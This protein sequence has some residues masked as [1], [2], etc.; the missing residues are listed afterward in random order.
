MQRIILDVDTGL[1]DAVALF[2]AAGLEEIK[3]EAV[4]ATAGNVGLDK[5]LENTLNIMETTG[6]DCPVYAGSAAPLV[7]VPVEAGDFHG[8][9]GLDGPI[10][11]TR[12]RQ[13]VQAQSGIDAMITLVTN[14][15]QEITIVSVGPLTDLARALQREPAVASL[16]KEFV[17]MGGS[18]SSG[19]VTPEAEFNTYADPEAAKIVFSSGAKIA[20]FSLDCT[21]TVTLS[22]ERLEGFRAKSGRSNEVFVACMDTYTANYT[23]RRQGEPQMHDPLCVAYLIDPSKVSGAYHGVDVILE[24]GPSYGKTIKRDTSKNTFVAESI[25]IPWFWTL[26]ER[27]LAA[28]P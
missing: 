22:A 26:V 1:D 15:P 20:L 8:E 5:T 3:I 9:T 19:N 14:N 12:L 6:L 24:E 10:F 28:L 11:A 13:E 23:K 4:I 18:F 7:R 2:L 16:A 21:R 27:A 25:D 17:I